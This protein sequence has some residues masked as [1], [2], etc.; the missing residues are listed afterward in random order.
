MPQPAVAA[1]RRALPHVG[2]AVET[3]SAR[4]VVGL[5]RRLNAAARR[6]LVKALSR[7]SRK[8]L[9]SALRH[10]ARFA[11]AVPTRELFTRDPLHNEWTMIL[12]LEYAAVAKSRKTG[13]PIAVA[14][15]ASY[16]SM[17]TAHWSREMGFKLIGSEAQRY[18]AILRA[19]RKAEPTSTRRKRRGLRGKHLRKAWRA[20]A[21]LRANT[22]AAV[23]R[24]AAVAT[25]WQA[26]A[27]AAEVAPGAARWDPRK[28]PTRADLEHH[29]K[30]KGA[31][32]VLW[33]RPLKKKTCEKVPIVFAQGREDGADTYY[34]LRRLEKYDS[35]PATARDS[36]PLFRGATGKAMGKQEFIRAME[37]VAHAA[38]QPWAA[39]KGHSA[40]IGGATDLADANASPLWLQG[41]G[42]WG[43]DVGRIYTRLTRRAQLAASRAM[44]RGKKGR[45]LEEIFPEYVQPAM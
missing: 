39:F 24:F 4:G 21:S 15:A 19:L 13:K 41:K 1:T 8:K 40:R 3:A 34:M 7:A 38:G 26:L 25:A 6:R 23:N 17:L 30:G 28:S 14:S 22:P 43:S 44:M 5:L 45:D 16:A 36:T 2:G 42:R 29:G 9:A 32:Y 10:F 33:L 27:R 11:A 12:Y 37:S 18:P 35:V 31:H 20:S